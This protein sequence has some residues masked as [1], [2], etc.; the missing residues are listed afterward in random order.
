MKTLYHVDID[1]MAAVDEV[2][3]V[4]VIVLPHNGKQS[5]RSD[6]M[7][8]RERRRRWWVIVKARAELLCFV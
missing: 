7:K 1:K 6:L 8:L 3:V 5:L 2:I 4:M